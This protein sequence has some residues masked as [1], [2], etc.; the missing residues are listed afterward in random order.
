[1]G[2][3]IDSRKVR[4]G[5]KWIFQKITNMTAGARPLRWVGSY[6]PPPENGTKHAQNTQQSLTTIK[7]HHLATCDLP[8]VVESVHKDHGAKTEVCECRVPSQGL[9]I[10]EHH[11][12]AFLHVAYR[13]RHD[14]ASTFKIGNSGV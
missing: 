9:K 8:S 13:H 10:L 6:T 3:K 14:D 7:C 1:M 5:E 2:V 12:E 4:A 11:L